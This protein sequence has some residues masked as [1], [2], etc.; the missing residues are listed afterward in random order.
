MDNRGE[1]SCYGAGSGQRKS[2]CRHGHR[3][4]GL[5]LGSCCPISQE[6]RLRP[7]GGKLQQVCRTLGSVSGRGNSP[8]HGWEGWG[9]ER[10]EHCRNGRLE[11]LVAQITPSGE[12]RDL[13]H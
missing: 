12:Q 7:A 10:L 2:R 13:R 8:G 11:N 3:D 9:E 6:R 5:F 4:S 1:V